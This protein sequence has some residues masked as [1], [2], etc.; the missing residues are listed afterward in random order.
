MRQ[1]HILQLDPR[2]EAIGALILLA[3][4]VEIHALV[5]N[6]VEKTAIPAAAFS[7][8]VEVYEYVREHLS[9]DFQELSMLF[10]RTLPRNGRLWDVF[11]SAEFILGPIGSRDL[12]QRTNL[13]AAPEYSYADLSSPL[14]LPDFL[15]KMRLL[16]IDDSARWLLCD[17]CMR[18][19]HYLARME[20]WIHPA[21]ECV[22]DKADLLYPYLSRCAEALRS[23]MNEV[24][25]SLLLDRA[26]LP[27]HPEVVEIIPWAMGFSSL[28]ARSNLGIRERKERVKIYY[29]A[30]LPA[31][32][33][34]QGEESEASLLACL[35]ALSDRSRLRILSLL[36]AAP[37]HGQE[38]ARRTRLSAGTVSHHMGELIAC[39]LVSQ[40]KQG[41]RVFYRA[42]QE[43]LE[44][45][46]DDLRRKLL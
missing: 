13:F 23:Q 5:Q 10:G 17:A 7:G 2:L 36:A 45:F 24:S 41:T 18:Y 8:L 25:L 28:I 27:T 12:S 38:I 46:L 31:L 19:E 40:E 42:R 32:E 3:D 16:P 33:Q 37:L 21:E 39:G 29:G 30:L 35:H 44:S 14:S 20:A 9:G 1:I 43:G 15:E 34:A 22:A 4:Q 11:E 6:Y 26:G